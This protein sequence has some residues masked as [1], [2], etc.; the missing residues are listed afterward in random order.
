MFQNRAKPDHMKH[1]KHLMGDGMIYTHQ[2]LRSGR[3]IP[4]IWQ[5]PYLIYR[6][7]ALQ[8]LDGSG[9]A[10]PPPRCKKATTRPK[11]VNFYHEIT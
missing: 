1:R 2:A 10:H 3:V 4:S 11:K 8:V 5:K 6:V 7:L 9:W